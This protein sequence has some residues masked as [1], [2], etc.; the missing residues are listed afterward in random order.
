MANILLVDPAEVARK[1]MSGILARGGHR[2]ASAGTVEEAW[3]F[4][5]QNV[6]VDLIFLELRLEGLGGLELLPRLRSDPFLKLMPVVVYTASGDR[7][8][9]RSALAMKVQNFLVKPYR[10]QAIFGEIAKVIAN[11]WRARHFE[12]EKSFCATM[13]YTPDGLRRALDQLHRGLQQ[14][15][16]QWRELARDENAAEIVPQV[17]ALSTKAE[18]AGAWGVVDLLNDIAGQAEHHEWPAFASR[19]GTLDFAEKLIFAHLN[20]DLVTEGFITDTERNAASEARVRALWFNAPNEGRCPVVPWSQITEAIEKLPGCPVIDS[21]AAAFQ[22]SATG[23]PS[24]LAPLMD[25]VESDPGLCATVLISGNKIRRANADL[26]A[27][28]VENPRICVNLLGE[29]KLA[30][31]ATSLVTAE[32]R[33]MI[34]PPC[35]WTNFWMFQVGVARM[36]RYICRYLEFDSLQARAYVAGLMHDI[37]K[38]LL[39]HLHPIGFQAILEYSRR[40]NVPLATAEEFFVGGTTRQMATLF[41]EKQGLLPS[42]ANVMRWLDRPTEATADAVLVAT[43]SLAHELCRQN[44]V[45]WSGDAMTDE[46]RS[47]TNTAAWTILR[48]NLFPSFDLA[49]FEA[50]AHAKSRE[51]KDTLRGEV[52][53][54]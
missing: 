7:D 42:F 6:T 20:R 22:M 4:I 13:G 10:D 38:L 49:K 12:E 53:V 21:A 16:L 27:E 3:R 28:P 15:S 31:L 36:A 41:A 33:V 51:L 25:L 19:L 39:L 14:G 48:E 30:A 44:R 11:P 52:Q 54:N 5:Q 47:I 9:V 17:Q 35:S 29:I 32:A 46:P 40:K 43:V 8:T 24:S 50:D 2:L 34:M 18:A 37:G 26:D 23:R 45:G 1:A